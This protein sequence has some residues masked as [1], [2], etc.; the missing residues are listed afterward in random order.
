MNSNLLSYET[1]QIP[2]AL[3]LDHEVLRAELLR[4]TAEPGRTGK[5]A[6]HVAQLCLAHFE[7][8]EDNVLRAFGSL[9]DLAADRVRPSTGQV[10]RMIDQFS[11]QDHDLRSQ[12]QL[13]KTAVEDLLEEARRF[14]NQEIVDMVSRL[15]GHEKIE[16]EA[17]YPAVLMIV[18]SMQ[19]PAEI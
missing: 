7:K 15:K 10:A 11:T 12:H 13:I 1:L 4:A 9:Y 5:A 19:G 16:D 8:E 18:R 2:Q 17:I 14:G 3:M 6:K